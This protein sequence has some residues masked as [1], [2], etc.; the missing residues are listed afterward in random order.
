MLHSIGHHVKVHKSI[1]AVG[2]ERADIEI[3]DYVVLPHRRD[4]CLPPRP[5]ILD[6]TMTHDRYGRSN[7]L[8]AHVRRKNREK[9]N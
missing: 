8:R 9:Q 4:T 5:L 3:K 2:N 1:P 7:V 6:F